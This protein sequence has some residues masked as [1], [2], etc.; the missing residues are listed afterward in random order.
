MPV[1]YLAYGHV[2]CDHGGGQ[3]AACCTASS[4]VLHAS[5]ISVIMHLAC[6]FG[7]SF[8]LQPGQQSSCACCMCCLWFL[9]YLPTHSGVGV[10]AGRRVNDGALL[11][12]P[13]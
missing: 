4:V 8:S 1:C 10:Q 7:V 13:F 9:V 11:L 5:I 6:V 3:L 12:L 2:C